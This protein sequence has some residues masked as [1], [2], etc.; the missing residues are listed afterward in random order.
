MC[1]SSSSVKLRESIEFNSI[2]SGIWLTSVVPNFWANSFK[3]LFSIPIYEGDNI[4][5]C[6]A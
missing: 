3:L 6:I 4:S 2:L 1:F 5:A